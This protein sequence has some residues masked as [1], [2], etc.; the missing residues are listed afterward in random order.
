MLLQKINLQ[1]QR[2]QAQVLSDPSLYGKR[3]FAAVQL[4]NGHLLC[5][6]GVGESRDSL[7]SVHKVDPYA[8]NVALVGSLVQPRSKFSATTHTDSQGRQF[9]VSYGGEVVSQFGTE[10]SSIA[11]LEVWHV[12][13]SLAE[14]LPLELPLDLGRKG[15]V[16]AKMTESLVL[17]AGGE[18]DD[19]SISDAIYVLDVSVQAWYRQGLPLS[20]PV[21]YAA[22]TFHQGRVLIF[23]GLTR[24]GLATRATQFWQPSN[25][26]IQ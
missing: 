11:S 10:T 24:E 8:A 19:G 7:S 9:V 3:S 21:A 13:D 22:A 2:I 6:G 4:L 25:L 17:V 15:L 12:N 5:L 1:T 20:L 16:V 26:L 23:G 14:L 18:L